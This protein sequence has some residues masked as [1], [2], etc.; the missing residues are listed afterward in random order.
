[1]STHTIDTTTKDALGDRMK[2]YESEGMIYFT[3]NT[4]VLARLDGRAFHTW[5]RGLKRPYDEGLT[6]LMIETTFH[7]VE[8]SGAVTGYTQSDE[9]TLLFYTGENPCEMF[10]GARKDK[11]VSLL[12]SIAT[13]KFNSKVAEYVPAKAGVLA[14]FDCRVWSVPSAME[15]AN[16]FVWRELDAIKN[17]VS[18]A[19]QS[20]FSH[21]E[22]NNVGAADKIR[23]LREQKG[24]DYDAYPVSFK[25]GTYVQRITFTWPFKAEN[26]DML[27]EKHHARTA[28]SPLKVV[29]TRPFVVDLPN[30]TSVT[31]RVE[32]LTLG[33]P[34]SVTEDGLKPSL[35][36]LI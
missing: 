31:N 14:H 29:R 22:L 20:V 35:E 12:A 18:M 7:L 9:I 27:P 32:V 8:E 23:M 1:M 24:I 15:A 25:R 6:R 26:L 36:G 11:L 34:F 33:R 5:S 4:Y 10:M 19:A 21:D 2:A 16:V 30:L 3:P 28:G 17:S 13:A